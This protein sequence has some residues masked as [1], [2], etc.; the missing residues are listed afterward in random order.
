MSLGT[1][2]ERGGTL[3]R[4]EAQA[5]AKSALGHLN[6]DGK[7][8]YWVRNPDGMQQVHPNKS[9]VGTIPQSQAKTTDGRSGSIPWR[10]STL[11]PWFGEY[12]TVSMPL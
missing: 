6:N 12:S 10:S 4:E 3:S 9:L 11:V 1:A 8:Y 5:A 2:L 7:S